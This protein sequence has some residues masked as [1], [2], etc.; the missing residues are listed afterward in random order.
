MKQTIFIEAFGMVIAI[1]ILLIAVTTR[2]SQHNKYEDSCKKA[3]GVVVYA[4]P[5]S[6]C[7]N[8][9]TKEFVEIK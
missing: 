4:L 3:G 1:S 9:A 2:T 6:N 8:N 7:Y 5:I